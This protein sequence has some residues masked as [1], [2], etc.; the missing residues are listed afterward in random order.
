MI[1]IDNLLAF[2]AASGNP[3]RVGM[4][5]SGFMGRGIANQTLTQSPA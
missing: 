1:I 4:I 5:G 3:I 2:R